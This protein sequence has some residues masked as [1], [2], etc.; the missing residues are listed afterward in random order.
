M[1]NS[2]NKM[3]VGRLQQPYEGTID[4]AEWM[5]RNKFHS[6]TKEAFRGADYGTALWKCET[7]FEYGVRQLKE[8]M[9]GV[10]LM[11]GL[12]SIGYAV[13]LFVMEVAK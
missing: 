6:T 11:A 2:K 4:P 5:H 13:V 3:V 1:N 7:E 10:V 12:A 9:L 8:I